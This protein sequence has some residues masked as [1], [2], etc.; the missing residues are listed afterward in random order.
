MKEC[1]Q[2]QQLIE[3]GLAI[4]ECH[5]SKDARWFAKDVT[6]LITELESDRRRLE[7]ALQDI[8]GE[9][10]EGKVLYR[11]RLTDQGDYILESVDPTN[12]GD[13]LLTMYFEDG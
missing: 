6:K 7:N 11:I 13:T 1:D 12:L 4:A 9:K 10:R 3:E 5:P 2:V 8:A